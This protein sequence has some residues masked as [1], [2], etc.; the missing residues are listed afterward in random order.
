MA[1]KRRKMA[2]KRRKR[3]TAISGPFRKTQ[4]MFDLNTLAPGAD[5][6][7]LAHTNAAV[8]AKCL[9]K[10]LVF[11]ACLS[12]YICLEFQSKFKQT[13]VDLELHLEI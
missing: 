9:F 11:G 3:K 7:A 6:V 5:Q 13:G 12:I 8:G 1:Q 4:T 10:L 2:Q